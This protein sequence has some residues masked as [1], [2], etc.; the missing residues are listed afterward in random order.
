MQVES[1]NKDELTFRQKY[2]DK[3]DER[4]AEILEALAVPSYSDKK[5]FTDL[6]RIEAIRELLKESGYHETFIQTASIWSKGSLSAQKDNPCYLIST[7]ADLVPQITKPFSELKENGYYKGTYDN[8]GTNAAAVILMLEGQ[9]PDNVIFTF[10]TEE[11]TGKCLGAKDT[12]ELLT[13][14]L[15]I[16][17]LTCFAL[18]VTYEGQDEGMLVSIENSSHND[19]FLQTLIQYTLVLQDNKFSYVPKNK[20]T[21]TDNI[22]K[23]CISSE[24]GMFD[25]A[26]V[27]RKLTKQACSI[28][29]P[30]AGIMHSN[31]GMTVRQPTFEGYINALKGI[32]YQFTKTHTDLI[33]AL[34]VQ[35]KTLYERNQELIEKEP[36]TP[37]Y[38]YSGND[39]MQGYDFGNTGYQDTYMYYEEPDEDIQNYL[40]ETMFYE[41]DCYEADQAEQFLYDIISVVNPDLYDIVY[42]LS[43]YI[44]NEFQL[45]FSNTLIEKMGDIFSLTNPDLSRE[46]R[47][48]V[49]Y[50]YQAFVEHHM[51]LGD[52]NYE[53]E[54]EEEFD[55][56]DYIDEEDFYL[57]DL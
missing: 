41:I 14:K 52:A 16:T 13:T 46:Y 15:G 51:M 19:D 48:I 57:D 47:E 7:H 22:P 4:H 42:S 44:Q 18:D 23:E 45:P 56:T 11:E 37:S 55:S 25:E 28:C 31:S 27:Y 50:I 21:I 5:G 12:Y 36:K 29:L 49:P 9:L 24:M 53:D 17:D 8:I 33:P 35:Q 26:F 40:N 34:T 3:F 43:D 30:S 10:T 38:M 39:Y 1:N 2:Y 20:K 32:L 54:L 6:S